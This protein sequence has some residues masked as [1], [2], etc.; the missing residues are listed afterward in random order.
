MRDVWREWKEGFA[1]QPAVQ[2][3]EEKWGS[4]WRPGNVVRVQFCR[5]KVL[6]DELSARIARGKSEEEAIGELEQLRAGRSLNR[7]I[8]DLKQ[9]RQWQAD[10]KGSRTESRTVVATVQGRGQGRRGRWARWGRRGGPPP[11]QPA[12]N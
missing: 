2:E 11:R 12:V 8:D 10:N 3:L 6:W 9:R 5:R 4:H 1:G 7:L